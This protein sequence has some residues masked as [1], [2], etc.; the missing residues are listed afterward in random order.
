MELENEI[1][2]YEKKIEEK[3]K[4]S[5][6]WDNNADRN[7]AVKSFE[8][9]IKEY[10]AEIRKRDSELQNIKENHLN[11]KDERH[12]KINEL[13]IYRQNIKNNAETEFKR[14]I[15]QLN[16]EYNNEKAKLV[17]REKFINFR[18]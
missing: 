2:G 9:E 7:K 13:N 1:K 15:E 17:K 4:G 6:K 11:D 8:I 3:G 18:A 16:N 5:I 14:T 12:N 10:N